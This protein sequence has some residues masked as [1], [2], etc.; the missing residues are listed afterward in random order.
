MAAEGDFMNKGKVLIE[1][2]KVEKKKK[3][4]GAA[5]VRPDGPRA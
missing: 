4:G 3:V 2:E 5:L 1:W